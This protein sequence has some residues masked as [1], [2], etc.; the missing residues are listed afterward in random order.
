MMIVYSKYAFPDVCCGEFVDDLWDFVDKIIK[1]TIFIWLEES[2]LYDENGERYTGW[3]DK[4][5]NASPIMLSL[6]VK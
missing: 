3:A 5:Y 4:S 1:K 6:E 2:E